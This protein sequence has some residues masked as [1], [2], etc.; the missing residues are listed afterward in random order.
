MKS[1]LKP[2][3]A[4]GLILTAASPITALPAAA[5]S[6]AGVGV[7]DL[8]LV[9]S[10]SNAYKVAEQQRPT[11][12]AAQIA[13][14]NTRA[15]QINAQLE[16][17]LQKLQADSQSANP[18]QASIEQQAAAIDQIYNQGQRDVNQIMA[19]VELSRSYV[20]EQIGAQLPAAVKNAAEKRNISLVLRPNQLLF[21]DPAYDI[22][23]AVVA[24][25]DALIPVAQLVP[26]PGWLPRE[27]REQQAALQAAQQGVQPASEAAP[28]PVEAGPAA[29]GR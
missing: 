12:Y 28:A 24:E 4:A 29:Q 23:T 18:N 22:T 11:T 1:L 17:L 26:P 2:V 10:T 19:P 6:V 7:V 25:L 14:A 16:P 21:A 27:L 20:A 13:Q 8:N 5:Q 3:L 15:E 9:I